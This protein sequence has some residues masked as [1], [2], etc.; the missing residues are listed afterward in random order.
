MP[1][2][3]LTLA[4]IVLTTACATLARAQSLDLLYAMALERTLHCRG[5][6]EVQHHRDLFGFMLREFGE[7][8]E[9]VTLLSPFAIAESLRQPAQGHVEHCALHAAGPG[10]PG[11]VRRVAVRAHPG[12]SLTASAR[13]LTRRAILS[14]CGPLHATRP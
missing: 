9:A 1:S 10:V 11:C 14:A 13:L 7:T 12:R 2:R 4:V 3:W 8:K 5:A 6:L